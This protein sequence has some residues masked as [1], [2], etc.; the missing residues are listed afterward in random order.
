[1]SVMRVSD[2]AA[3]RAVG[4][5]V[6]G[7]LPPEL[8]DRVL[9]DCRDVSVTQGY[10]FMGADHPAPYRTGLVVQGLLRMFVE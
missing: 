1:M 5:S 7:R 9:D 8:L 10:R 4:L 3:V 2:P 6:F